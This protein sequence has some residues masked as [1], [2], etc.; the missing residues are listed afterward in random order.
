MNTLVT[1]ITLNIGANSA[2]E[3]GERKE[4]NGTKTSQVERGAIA[5]H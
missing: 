2:R 4:N 5:I 3:T 1:A